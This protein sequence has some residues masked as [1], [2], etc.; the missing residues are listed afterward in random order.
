M[1]IISGKYKGRQ[2]VSFQADNIRPTTDRVKETL[3]NKLMGYIDGARVLDLFSGTGNL[4]IECLSRGAAH[5]DLVENHRKSLEIIKKNMS[6]LKIG[7]GFKIHPVDAFKYIQS[8]EGPAYDVIIADPPFTQSYGHELCV[9]IGESANLGSAFIYVVEASS[10]ERVD[11]SYP[12][13]NR[14]DRREFGDKHLNFF[15]KAT[16]THGQGDIPR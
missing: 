13:L 14:L 15:E 6:A 16:E 12:G 4:A 7:E 1:R 11:E 2:L 9:K 10:K 5:V 8:Y 3:F